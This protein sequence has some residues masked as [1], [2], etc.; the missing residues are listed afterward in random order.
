M[1]LCQNCYIGAM[2]RTMKNLC[3]AWLEWFGVPNDPLESAVQINIPA[4]LL[5]GGHS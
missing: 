2:T 5:Y 1:C 3:Y 4:G